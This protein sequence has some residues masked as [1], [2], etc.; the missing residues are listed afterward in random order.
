MKTMKG[1]ES[2]TH[3]ALRVLFWFVVPIAVAVFWSSIG[4]ALVAW[5]R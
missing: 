1:K 2:F 5:L 4:L 3:A